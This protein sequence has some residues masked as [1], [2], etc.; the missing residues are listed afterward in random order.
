MTIWG[1]IGISVSMPRQH[2]LMLF[3]VQG[4]ESDLS[5]GFHWRVMAWPLIRMDNGEATFEVL[6]TQRQNAPGHSLIAV[7][8]QVN[9]FRFPGALELG[10]KCG[11]GKAIGRRVEQ[12]DSNSET[13]TRHSSGHK[14]RIAQAQAV[15]NLPQ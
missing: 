6:W 9:S 4:P 15:D 1:S 2:I 5:S 7:D 14:Q 3:G 12:A 10:R 13:R 8:I 11:G